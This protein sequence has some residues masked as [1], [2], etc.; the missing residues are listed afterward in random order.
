[1]TWAR[2]GWV[3]L[4]VVIG[5]SITP[6]LPFVVGT[7]IDPSWGVGLHMATH[8]RLVFGRDIVFTF[9]PLGF[10][11][12]PSMAFPAQG[13]LSYGV[14]IPLCASVAWL[15]TSRLR[16][17]FRERLSSVPSALLAVLLTPP[18][19]WAIAGPLSFGGEII[20][21]PLL[22]AGALGLEGI[23]RGTP[24]PRIVTHAGLGF[25]AAAA[26]LTKF[27]VGLV[28]VALAL[29]FAAAST[30]PSTAESTSDR[31]RRVRN[32][33]IGWAVGVIV[34]WMLARQPLGALP[35]WLGRSFDV[36]TGFSAAMPWAY[37]PTWTTWAALIGTSSVIATIW[38]ARVVRR[39]GF[40]GAAYVVVFLGTTLAQ[41]FRR[42]DPGHV[43]RF[44]ALL[45]LTV[46]L[47]ATWRTLVVSTG[48]MVVLVVAVLSLT[49][50][51]PAF[52]AFGHVRTE[53]P[54][55]HPSGG[56][57]VTLRTLTFAVSPYR[58][59]GRLKREHD[60]LGPLI[61]MPENVRAVADAKTVHIEPWETSAAWIFGWK[62]KPLPV[63]QSYSAYTS[64]LDNL[65]ATALAST[66]RAPQVVVAQ[67]VAIDGRV[68]RF[69][70][71]NTQLTLLC[72][73]RPAASGGGW[74]AFERRNRS[75][76]G[77]P[78][79]SGADL[80]R[81]VTSN[82]SKQTKL[83]DSRPFIEPNQPR[84]AAGRTFNGWIVHADAQI[85]AD[86]ITVV[87]FGGLG[88]NS[89]RRVVG[90]PPSIVFGEN[91][92]HR[93]IAAT[94]RG[95]H[96]L[97]VPDCLRE[98]LGPGSG[99]DATTWPVFSLTGVTTYTYEIETIPYD[100]TA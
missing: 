40:F 11:V 4:A 43:L 90:Q 17:V 85:N 37:H 72:W 1:M 10:L 35:I 47:F 68:P 54:F 25:A 49:Q 60:R 89:L 62:W 82:V 28:A 8:L 92:A 76:C 80:V 58:R 3:A 98:L 2:A 50:A 18:I 6:P 14:R 52:P 38:F 32:T 70:S 30:S 96:V 79:G 15:V 55:V 84:F 22:V 7:G 71:P 39:P 61:G 73:Y 77:G 29:L 75:A 9:G 59:A 69:E 66:R 83:G 94:S 21:I 16:R 88:D 42:Y 46:L 81:Q 51:G 78:S 74:T 27:D 53:V 95:A 48:V 87:R 13:V 65:N 86:A 93:L 34:L 97:A 5:I 64:A 20:V 99:Y 33:I 67:S 36:T 57:R 63:F 100:C 56:W 23:L 24:P 19:A 41:S 31:L 45:V 26:L 44:A 12:A 91:D